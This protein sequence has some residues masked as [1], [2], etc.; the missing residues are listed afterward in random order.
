MEPGFQTPT[1]VPFSQWRFSSL[2][3]NL[4]EI[5]TSLNWDTGTYKEYK[6]W[7][8]NDDAGKDD[9]IHN[10]KAIPGLGA[11]LATLS[12]NLPFLLLGPN[13]T[14]KS[15]HYLWSQ[16]ICKTNMHPSKYIDLRTQTI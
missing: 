15:K 8:N 3:K 13:P 11:G 6:L 10:I 12:L 14:H 2:I 16:P 7:Q 5:K 1:N 9:T 4:H